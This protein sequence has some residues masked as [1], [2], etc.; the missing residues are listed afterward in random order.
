MNS[1]ESIQATF[2]AVFPELQD[3]P[4]DRV[5]ERIRE[6]LPI[7]RFDR[8]KEL[9]DISVQELASLVGISSSTLGRRRKSGY[10]SESESERLWRVGQLLVR[11]RDVLEDADLA[12]RW[13]K[14]PKRALGGKTPLEYAETE[15][16]AR[17]VEDLLGRL[18]HGVFS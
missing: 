8:L 13:L 17:E 3:E 10:L 5:I 6:G 11:A 7:E 4:T 16:G 18:E 1:A 14:T 9:L 2:T 12:R 15:P